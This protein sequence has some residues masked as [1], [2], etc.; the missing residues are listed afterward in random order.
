M[1]DSGDDMTLFGFAKTAFCMSFDV[2]IQRLTIVFVGLMP[3][4]S[5]QSNKIKGQTPKR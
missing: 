3:E 4:L 2:F 1:W 5:V